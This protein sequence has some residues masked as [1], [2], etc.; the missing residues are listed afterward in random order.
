MEINE[1]A[2]DCDGSPGAFTRCVECGYDY[3]IDETYFYFDDDG[4]LK[5]PCKD[6]I[7]ESAEKKAG[8]ELIKAKKLAE[9]I[10]GTS[11]VDKIASGQL[12]ITPGMEK[13]ADEVMEI[14]GG[15]RSLASFVYQEFFAAPAG[16]HVRLGYIDKIFRLLKAVDQARAA[17][18]S[19]E[20]DMVSDADI[21]A[22]LEKMMGKEQCSAANQ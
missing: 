19:K 7:R 5:Q 16:G 4:C 18:K 11:V 12:M 14:F 9:N 1:S 6:C 15:E 21:K 13:L 17:Q 2:V 8:K 3:P 22:Y 10:L 20:S